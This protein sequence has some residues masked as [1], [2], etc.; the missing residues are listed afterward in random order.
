MP[1]APPPLSTLGE[2]GLIRYLSHRFGRT[3]SSVRRGIGDDAAVFQPLSGRELLVTTDLLAEGIHFDH[4]TASYADIGYKAAIANLSD[5]AA[6]GG[7]PHYVL[8]SMAIPPLCTARDITHLYRGLMQGCR[9]HRV[10]LIGGDTSASAGGLFVS[11]MLIGSIKPRH[12]LLRTGARV[13]DL[14]YVSGTLGDSRAGLNLLDVRHTTARA[15]TTLA[16]RHRHFLITRHLRPTAR[17]Q[18]GQLLASSKLAT[19]AI[20]VSDGLAGDLAHVCDQSGVGAEIDSAAIPCSSA[21]RSTG[22][23]GRRG[24]RVALHRASS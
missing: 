20:D 19:S 18:L 12:A 10:E 17:L 1:A 14:L 7:V 15:A 24:L 5:I 13:G 2:F 8:V 6:M 23:A 4:R 9:P 16:P 3:G 11:I 21:C 22:L